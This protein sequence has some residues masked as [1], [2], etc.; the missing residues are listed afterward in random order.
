MLTVKHGD[1]HDITFTVRD[2]ALNTTV[3]LTGATAKLH[4]QLN[5]GGTIHVLDADVTDP[6]QGQVTHTLDGTL[7]VGCY[8]VEIELERNGQITTTPTDGFETL[9][10]RPDLA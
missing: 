9:T 3:D 6:K 7:P 2:E 10:V 8:D 4:A 5:T 1:T